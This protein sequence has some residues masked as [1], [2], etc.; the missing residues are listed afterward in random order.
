M[1]KVHIWQPDEDDRIAGMLRDKWT[2]TQIGKAMGVSRN[3]IIG[4]VNRSKRLKAIGF[5]KKPGVPSVEKA[6]SVRKVRPV[7]PTVLGNLFAVVAPVEPVYAQ[8][9]RATVGVPMMMLRPH[10]CKW[11]VNDAAKGDHHLFCGA[12]SDD[13]YCPLHTMKSIGRGTEGERTA[14]RVLAK[15]A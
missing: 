12:E 9:E 1:S 11:A 10:M 8:G 13:S 14:D 5:W 15:A 7:S 6:R 2:A 4:R 3:A